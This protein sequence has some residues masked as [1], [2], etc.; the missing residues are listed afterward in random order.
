MEDLSEQQKSIIDL[1]LA[2]HNVYF[3]GE[4]GTGKT[5]TLKYIVE[6]LQAKYNDTFSQK[7]AI[8]AMTGI[9]AT[10]IGGC[11]LNSALGFGV[12][13]TQRDFMSM[14]SSK[15]RIRGFDVLI[16]DES[17][18]CSAELFDVLERM[19]RNIRGNQRPA[20][21]L[22]LVITGDPF[23]LP[24]IERSPSAED[25]DDTFYNRG[26]FFAA[27][28]WERCRFATMVL[29]QVFRQSDKMFVS[30][31]NDIRFGGQRARTAL[32]QLYDICHRPLPIDDGIIP[33]QIFSRNA[34]VDEMNAT[35][36]A[37]LPGPK[38]VFSARD[39]VVVVASLRS[40]HKIFI[41]AKGRLQRSDFFKNC[42][43][44]M[45]LQ[46]C[47]GAQV[48]LLKNIDTSA[49]LVNGSRGVVKSVHSDGVLVHFKGHEGAVLIQ[50]ARFTS[51][52]NG[53]GECIRHQIPLKLAWS[54]SS[55]KSQGCTLD[56]VRVSLKGTFACGQ[57]YVALSRARTLDGLEIVDYSPGCAKTDASVVAFFASLVEKQ[58]TG[59]NVPVLDKATSYMFIESSADEDGDP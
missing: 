1:V 5:T 49:N 26:Y 55:H 59:T 53:V 9:A 57:A 50:K 17:S 51:T 40:D 32:D 34:M 23:Q 42:Q 2:G 45:K 10:H 41:S 38:H 33:T 37:K 15:E 27:S 8:T 3:T 44:P 24:P 19:L 18:M 14:Y 20:G 11:T 43:A 36:L 21:G 22:Q 47:V 54:L 35:E 13:N 31:L 29:T 30:L 48:M 25:P 6:A 58:A 12:V 39:E 7:V 56:Y 46:L 28:S 4:A 52:V 16:I